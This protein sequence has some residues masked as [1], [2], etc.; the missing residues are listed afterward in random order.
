MKFFCIS[1]DFS[2]IGFAEIL[3]WTKRNKFRVLCLGNEKKIKLFF[4]VSLDFS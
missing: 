1:L 3:G 2:Y 4:C